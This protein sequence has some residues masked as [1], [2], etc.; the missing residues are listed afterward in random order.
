MNVVAITTVKGN[1]MPDQ[2]KLNALRLLEANGKNIPVYQGQLRPYIPD[3]VLTSSSQ[4]HGLDGFGDCPDAIP[5]LDSA[6][7]K[8]NKDTESAVNALIRLSKEYESIELMAI[9]PLTNLALA[10]SIDPELPS[11]FDRLTLMGGNLHGHGFI[12]T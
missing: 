8:M 3:I 10:F 9:G 11:R 7:S 6:K 1:S 5:T 4:Y 2:G 12:N